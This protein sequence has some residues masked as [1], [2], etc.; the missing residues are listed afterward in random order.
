MISSN[1][2]ISNLNGRYNHSIV[3]YHEPLVEINNNL[4]F[5]IFTRLNN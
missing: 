5:F 2:G 1:H 3:L 4:H